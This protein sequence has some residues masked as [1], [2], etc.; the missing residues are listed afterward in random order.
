LKLVFCT[1]G[2]ISNPL[3]ARLLMFVFLLFLRICENSEFTRETEVK[4]EVGLG[5]EL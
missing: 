1:L 5:A 2:A 3:Q 4:Q